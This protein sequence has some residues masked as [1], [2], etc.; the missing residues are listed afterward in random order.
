MQPYSASPSRGPAK[1]AIKT[2]QQRTVGFWL[3]RILRNIKDQPWRAASIVIA[4]LVGVCIAIAIIAASNGI[5][6]K[7]DGLLKTNRPGQAQLLIQSGV[8]IH[9]I[10]SVLDS[11]RSLLTKLAIGFTAALVGIVTWVNTSQRRRAIGIERQ[12]GDHQE[13]VIG[14]L[15]GESLILCTLGGILGIIAGNILCSFVNSDSLL[16]MHPGP[17]DIFAI[18][19]TTTLLTFGV[20]ASIAFFFA[21][22]IDVAPNMS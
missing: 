15:V 20:T 4:V 17:G 22:R 13:E 18:F 6:T 5:Q 12:G 8:D 9:E 11:T 16:P 10:Q 21:R 1:R 19:P 14:M 3:Y 7:I 2:R